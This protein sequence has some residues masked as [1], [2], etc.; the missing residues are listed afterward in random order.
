MNRSGC[1][2]TKIFAS[3]VTASTY[4]LLLANKTFHIRNFRCGSR[5]TVFQCSNLPLMLSALDNRKH[6]GV[7]ATFLPT[8]TDTFSRVH[9]DWLLPTVPFP[10]IHSWASRPKY[11]SQWCCAL[12][13]F[14]HYID[15][16]EAQAVER[17]LAGAESSSHMLE[18]VALPMLSRC[19]S[20][21]LPTLSNLREVVVR[22]ARYTLV[23]QPYYALKE[24]ACGMAQFQFSACP[25]SIHSTHTHCLTGVGDGYWTI[26]GWSWTAAGVWLSQMLYFSLTPENLSTFLRFVTGSPICGIQHI[27]VGFNA[28]TSSFTRQPSANTCASTIHLPTTYTSFSSF[29]QEFGCILDNSHLWTFDAM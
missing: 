2:E 5:T 28:A 19:N 29:A 9:V 24:M 21:S 3:A 10:S 15:D 12:Q 18:N 27:D 20:H 17:R 25:R 8:W 6:S 1:K 22:A 13:S 14:L 23:S 11:D 26:H 7:P 4:T 16:F